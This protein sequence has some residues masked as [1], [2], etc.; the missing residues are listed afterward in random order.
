MALLAQAVGTLFSVLFWL[1]II[2]SVLSWIRPSGYNKLLADV[3]RTLYVLTEPI[4]APIRNV[5]PGGGMG[6]DWSPL[7]ALLLL[8]IAQNIVVSLLFRL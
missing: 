3:N 8:E 5:I 6:M 4:L 7:V 2:R 1:I